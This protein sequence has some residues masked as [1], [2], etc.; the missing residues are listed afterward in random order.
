MDERCITK[1]DAIRVLATTFAIADQLDG[2]W[3]V[4]G[5]RLDGRDLTLIV[6]VERGVVVVTIWKGGRR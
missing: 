5:K 6:A 3:R 2:T 4:T 1:A